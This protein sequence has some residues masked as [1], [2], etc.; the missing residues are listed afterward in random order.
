MLI[1]QVPEATEG[2]KQDTGRKL[3]DMLLHRMSKA[4]E[5]K[6]QRADRKLL[7][8]VCAQLHTQ[9]LVEVLKYPFSTGEA[10]QIVLNQLKA[11]TGRDF[12]GNVWKFVEQADALGIKDVGSPA[13]RPSAQDAL[14]ELHELAAH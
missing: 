9:D 11:I 3:S 13:Q 12:A 14:K 4:A 7:A 10:E 1:Q 6:E 5:G 2:K 8:D